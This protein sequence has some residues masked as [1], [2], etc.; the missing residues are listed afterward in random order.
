M[1]GEFSRRFLMLFR[2]R[3]FD[4]DLDEEMRLHRELRQQEEIERGT[5]QEEAHY[6]AQRRFGNDLVLREE[7]RDMWAWNWLENFVQDV[8]YGLRQLRRNPGFT[9]VAIVT[10]ALGIGANTAIFSVINS[11]LLQPLPFQAP[12]RLVDLR[13][14]EVAPGDY[15]L[16]GPDYLDW[17]AQSH[18]LE[19][20]SLYSWTR[21]MSLSG[22]GEPEP[23][24]AVPTQANFFDVIGV[25]PLLGRGFAPGEDAAG[26]NRVAVLS[27]G[28]WQRRFAADP[29]AISKE[30]ELN[31]AAYTVVG[32]MP[33]WFNFPWAPDLWMPLDMSRKELGMRG[34][35]NW[36]AVG[37]IKPGV[38]LAQAR[39]E[40]LTISERLE[41]E[42]PNSNH[43]VHA[44]LIPLQETLV[45]NSRTPLLVLFGAVTLVLLVACANVA[46]LLLARATGRQREV[47]LRASLGASRSRLLRQLLTESLLLAL[48]GAALGTAG[49][50]WCVR[51]LENAKAVSLPRVHPIGVD[52]IAL[53]F[54][55]C[56]SILA[57]ILF[58]LAPALQVSARDL[59]EQLK[60]AAHG[61]VSAKRTSRRLRDGLVVGEI[62]VTLALLVGASL[63]LRSF[64]RMRSA[65]IGIRPE[66]LL[67]MYLDLPTEK[68][69][70]AAV[71]REFFD[72]LVDRVSHIPGV[73]AAALCSEIPIEGGSNGY[74]NV[75]GKPDPKFSKLLVGWN[76][77]TPDYFHVF[78]IPLLEGRSFTAE[79]LD[80]NASV[81]SMLEALFK[82]AQGGQPKIPPDLT[83]VSVISR[84]TAQTFWPNQDAVGKTFH[85]N[86]IKVIVIG[87]VGDVKEYGVRAKILP[88]AYYP[89][90]LALGDHSYGRL[91][92]KTRIPPMNVLGEIRHQM[93]GLDSGL[94]MFRARTMDEVIAGNTQDARFQALLLGA[95]AAV[96]VLLAVVGLYGVMSYLV[97]QRTR[98]I[99][100]RMALGAQKADALR[101]VIGQGLK[102]AI[103]GVA[104]GI[105][106][107]LGLTRFFSSLL[108]GV[109]P[110]DPLTFVAVSII[111]TAVALLACYIPARRATKVDPMVALRHE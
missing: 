5:S 3:R 96:A 38:T 27:Y 7:S 106:A 36:R 32:V 89:F 1:L 99:G 42:Y 18:T 83:L 20:A 9:I 60:T 35:H 85:W 53:A 64:A 23:A 48:T 67:T 77:I 62:A 80:R 87:V 4:A 95:F 63:L 79:D 86:N 76:F 56:V 58:G 88:Q 70:T 84:T 14:T 19:S 68:Y 33:R 50:W 28:F 30:I 103:T 97:A 52:G 92:I 29:H 107:A 100:I 40:L 98:E 51:A 43:N 81:A 16:S 37:R 24:A 39:A 108:Y 8:G 54:T 66:N 22:G 101:M 6:A 15:P 110:T 65:E 78:R 44:V 12:E 46:N 55:V 11:V 47:A 109:K 71:R 72:Q 45:G 49:A 91:V 94:A 13:E 105:A 74:I 2:R 82:A 90:T 26:K 93:R 17:Q 75:D 59:S 104:I 34:N 102:L 61:V 57:G 69:S 73:E 111:L 41:K 31:G 10:L 21:T 25:R